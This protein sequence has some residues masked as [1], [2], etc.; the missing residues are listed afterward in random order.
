MLRS[1]L[2]ALGVVAVMA[3]ASSANA[4]PVVVNFTGVG[5]NGT[6]PESGASWSVLHGGKYQNSMSGPTIARLETPAPFDNPPLSYSIS[7]DDTTGALNNTGGLAGASLNINQS[8]LLFDRDVANSSDTTGA[9][10]AYIL[11]LLD[12]TLNITYTP[13]IHEDDIPTPAGLADPMY[14]LT[15]DL[16]FQ[17]LSGDGSQL[18]FDSVFELKSNPNLPG[19]FNGLAVGSGGAGNL[20]VN[21][22]VFFIWAG[23]A[24]TTTQ[25]SSTKPYVG[26]DLGAWGTP[27]VVPA[28][29]GMLLLG[30]G[31]VG[32]A[33]LRR[34]A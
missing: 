6:G 14:G 26:I 11:R 33:G 21:D 23:S 7:Y 5:I 27:D 32:I 15:G 29:A 2:L 28:P 16:A 20:P 13:T 34:K 31:L 17:I 9:D 18:L 24:D 22:V 10:S 1:K 12:S 3:V 8:D 30:F 25:W 19:P 4:A